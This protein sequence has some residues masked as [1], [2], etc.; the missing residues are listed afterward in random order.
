MH[1]FPKLI[2]ACNRGS[3]GIRLSGGDIESGWRRRT[4]IA[5][6]LESSGL[7]TGHIEFRPEALGGQ[8]VG[9]RNYAAQARPRLGEGDAPVGTVVVERVHSTHREEHWSTTRR[10]GI[11]CQTP[12]DDP[13]GNAAVLGDDDES[14]SGSESSGEA[15]RVTLGITGWGRVRRT[16]TPLLRSSAGRVRR[17]K[18]SRA[19]PRP[20]AEGCDV[21]GRGLPNFWVGDLDQVAAGVVEHGRGDRAHVQ[22][23]LGEHHA[24][25]GQ[26]LVLGVHIVDGE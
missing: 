2:A 21:S 14:A 1:T 23:R 20:Q 10:I 25:L 22:R 9:D 5:T 19:G 13:D 17:L 11:T 12:V 4:H 18:R 15:E 7:E 26:T 16:R 8:Q 24:Q 6:T 3:L